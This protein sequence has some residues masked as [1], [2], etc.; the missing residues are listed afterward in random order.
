M[1]GLSPASVSS[2][3]ARK[4]T[5]PAR[6]GPRRRV[7]RFQDLR[8]RPGRRESGWRCP[9][10]G[11]AAQGNSRVPGPGPR[12]CP[13]RGSDEPGSYGE[14]ARAHLRAVLSWGW[15]REL[16]ETPPRFPKPREQ[17]D[18][19]G[20]HYL[21]KTEINALYFATHQMERPRGWDGPDPRWPVP[22]SRAGRILQLRCRYRDRLEVGG[23]SRAKPL[24]S[25]HV[26]APVAGPRTQGAV[27]LGVDVLPPGKD[28]QELLPADES[29]RAGAPQEHPAGERQPG[30]ACFPG[31]G[32]ASERAL[33]ADALAG[34]TG[35]ATR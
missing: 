31:R 6:L 10:R 34:N 16:I 5:S 3:C 18:V 13:G 4:P 7:T 11:A 17:R 24:A 26:G 30:H 22:A 32:S 28:G 19:A 21:T 8:C 29:R 14:Q 20:R 9:D 27:T 35:R 15:E 23:L 33:P 12:A 25:C 1:A 2:T